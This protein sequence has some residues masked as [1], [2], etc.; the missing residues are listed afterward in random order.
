[1]GVT[2][3]SNDTSAP[4]WVTFYI[5]QSAVALEQLTHICQGI[6]KQA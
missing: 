3:I 6:L 1:M 2:N 5:G 4:M